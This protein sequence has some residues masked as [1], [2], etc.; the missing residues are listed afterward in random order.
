M[1]YVSVC[2]SAKAKRVVQTA[3]AVHAVYVPGTTRVSAAYAHVSLS[4]AAKNAVRTAVVPTVERARRATCVLAGLVSVRPNAAEKRA[5]LTAV[6]GYVGNARLGTSAYKAS[7]NAYLTAL[8]RCVG[9]TAV[10][11]CAVP[12]IRTVSVSVAFA[13]RLREKHARQTVPM[14]PISALHYPT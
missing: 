9:R 2:P 11:V 6:A 7:V 8:A 4:V 3:V 12:V 1:V 5:D 14:E 10:V 13:K